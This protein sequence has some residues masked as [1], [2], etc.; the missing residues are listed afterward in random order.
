VWSR[1]GK[2]GSAPHALPRRT[3]FRDSEDEGQPAGGKAGGGPSIAGPS[4][5]VGADARDGKGRGRAG[6]SG[7]AAPSES[8]VE[9]GNEAVEEGVDDAW[10]TA[11]KLA[12]AVADPAASDVGEGVGGPGSKAAGAGAGLAATGDGAAKRQRAGAAGG[13]HAVLSQQL[14]A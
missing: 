13:W 1:A 2:P 5:A 14:S 12:A 8:Q 6:A 11:G 4:A 10:T 9:E 3:L 7:G